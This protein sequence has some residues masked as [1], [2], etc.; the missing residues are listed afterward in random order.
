MPLKRTS[1]R[2]IFICVRVL[3]VRFQS[4]EWWAY[5]C[6]CHFL[7]D[8]NKGKG[9]AV[10]EL[11]SKCSSYKN[12]LKCVAEKH[13]DDCNNVLR[14]YTWKWSSKANSLVCNS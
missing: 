12:C 4:S 8:S 9:R 6:Q 5:G 2:S 3:N 7:S 11:D 10:D 14:K 13:G 1:E